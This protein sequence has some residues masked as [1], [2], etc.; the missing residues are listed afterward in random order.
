MSYLSPN[1]ESTDF[2]FMRT[3]SDIRGDLPKTQYNNPN[4]IYDFF[5][6]NSEYSDMAELVEMAHMQNYY[7][8]SRNLTLFIAKNNH[9][10]LPENKGKAVRLLSSNTLSQKIPLNLLKEIV[11]SNYPT[12]DIYSYVLINNTENGVI[13]NNKIKL[14]GVSYNFGNSILLQ[15]DG[16]NENIRL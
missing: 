14:T 6:N 12:K 15:A 7:D 11:S 4:S 8:G 3:F 1:K 10:K 5:K 16:L 9:F 13:V 2:K